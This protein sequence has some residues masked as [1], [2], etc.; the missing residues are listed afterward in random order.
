MPN[1]PMKSA[2]WLGDPLGALG[3]AADGGEEGVHVGLGETDAVVLD[4][5][6]RAVGVQA[7]AERVGGR[8]RF[9]ACR[10]VIASTA[11]CSSSRR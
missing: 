7:D 9:E 5:D 2:R 4:A 3:A 10:A 8:G 11:F 1:W 6:H